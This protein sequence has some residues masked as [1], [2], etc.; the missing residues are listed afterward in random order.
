MTPAADASKKTG[1]VV[2]IADDDVDTLN[3]VKVKF[4][5]HGLT[6]VT[7]RDGQ[8]ALAAVRQHKPSLVILDV[9]MPRLN[10]FQ[11]ARM[12][13]FD[14]HTKPTPVILLT[15]RTQQADKDLG[16]QV[17]AEEYITKPFDPQQLLDRVNYW[18]THK[19]ETSA[20]AERS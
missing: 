16:R 5:A 20:A 14:K 6:V 13:K 15:A 10:G 2:V 9:M 17:G 1:A 8:A 3:I 7:V 18:L 19:D 12:I 4:E 11:V